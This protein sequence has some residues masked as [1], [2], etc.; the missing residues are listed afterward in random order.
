MKH[1]LL[2]AVVTS[3]AATGAWAQAGQ[4]HSGHAMPT[5]VKSPAGQM[6]NTGEVRRVN[7][8]AKKITIAHAP[9]KSFDMPAMTM[10]FPVKDPALLAKVKEGDK[11]RFALEKA[12][13][14]LVI[15][16]IEVVK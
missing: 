8:G 9:L 3:F 15:T 6:E 16:R 1:S 11:V 12:G 7:A 5:T 2:V 13:D 14:D 10:P 4:S